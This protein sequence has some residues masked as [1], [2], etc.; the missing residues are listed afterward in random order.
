MVIVERGADAFEA[1]GYGDGYG[2]VAT[3]FTS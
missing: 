2:Y 1:L 3:S